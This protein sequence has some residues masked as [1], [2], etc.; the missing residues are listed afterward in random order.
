MI[1]RIFALLTVWWY[2]GYLRQHKHYK[3]NVAPE[4]VVCFARRHSPEMYTTYLMYGSSIRTV[5][6]TSGTAGI[7]VVIVLI[8]EECI[9][10]SGFQLLC[11]H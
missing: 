1:Q 11:K 2:I 10:G 8:T 6:N 9:C 5:L 3:N 7:W 4:N